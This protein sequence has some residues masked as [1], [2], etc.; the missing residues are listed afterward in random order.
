MPSYRKRPP[1]PP[2]SRHLSK[3]RRFRG[4][5]DNRQT[6]NDRR[7]A[8]RSGLAEAF[9]SIGPAN[10]PMDHSF[11]GDSTEG[12]SVPLAEFLVASFGTGTHSA[13]VA[14]GTASTG[15][16]SHRGRLWLETA[17]RLHPR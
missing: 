17:T 6:T 14:I 12:K 5:Q 2:P 4:R 1:V 9:A 3:R 13:P 11:S 7:E 16:A 10:G 15:I 8:R